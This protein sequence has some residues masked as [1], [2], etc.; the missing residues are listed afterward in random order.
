MRLALKNLDLNIP[1]HATAKTA[2]AIFNRK[3]QKPSNNRLFHTESGGIAAQ[4]A[5]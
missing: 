1:L 5:L 2:E 3:K 4:C